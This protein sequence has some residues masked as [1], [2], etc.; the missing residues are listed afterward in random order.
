MGWTCFNVDKADEKLEIERLVTFEN[1]ER[2]MRPVYAVRKGSIW[3]LAVEVQL[4]GTELKCSGYTL[5][6]FGRYVFAA[7]IL[8]S[9]SG[10]EWCYKDMEESMGP[11]E[12]RAP[13]KLIG[14]L[15]ETDIEYA[16]NWRERCLQATG[17]TSRKVSHGDT[18]KLDEPLKFTDGAQRDTFKISKE[19]TIFNKRATTRFI[20]VDTGA[21]CRI[22]KFMRR[23]WQHIEV[24]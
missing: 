11:N 14:L 6:Q 24:A 9:R 1:E 15:S 3:Y 16:I 13:K 20:C 12:A 22:S 17:L 19:R 2:A 18:I 8:T 5:D 10:S 7:V 21:V 23:A 4:K